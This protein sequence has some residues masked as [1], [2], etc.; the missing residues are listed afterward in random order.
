MP[1]DANEFMKEFSGMAVASLI[2]LFSGYNQI[3][4]DER[5]RDITAIYTSLRLLYQEPRV[6]IRA[7]PIF[8]NSDLH[9]LFKHYVNSISQG[10]RNFEP[11]NLP[12]FM[13]QSP[14]PLRGCYFGTYMSNI[15]KS[16]GQGSFLFKQDFK[17]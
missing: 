14:H 2:D 1:P 4:L 5:D 11:R 10:M 7:M 13:Q 15:L 8:Q 3:T 16:P 17:Q 6:L 12:Y 9:S